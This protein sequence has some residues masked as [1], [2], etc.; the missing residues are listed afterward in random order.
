MERR[1]FRIYTTIYFKVCLMSETKL[2][3]RFMEK[4]IEK[5]GE[6]LSQPSGRNSLKDV[7]QKKWLKI[8]LLCLLGLVL[9]AGV[10]YAGLKMASKKELSKDSR[11]SPQVTSNSS[12]TPTESLSSQEA[13]KPVVNQKTPVTSPEKY[14]FT[15]TLELNGI[16][17]KAKFPQN[18]TV[19]LQEEGFYV[20]KASES[21]A[22]TFALKNYDGG[23]RRAWFQREYPWAKNYAMEPFTGAGHSG[24]IAYAVKPEDRPGAFFYFAVVNNKMLVVSGNNYI[25]NN[26]NPTLGNTSVFFTTDI[27]KFKSFL[28]TIELTSSQNVALETYPQIS[29]LYR[30]SNT[31]KTVWEDAT[32]GLKITTP[33]WTESRY[34]RERD[35]NGKFTYTDW[36]RTYPEAKTYD[37]SYFSEKIKRVEVT[38]AYASSQYLSV[39]S[40]KYQGKSFSEV[41]NELLIPA[42]F[43]TTEWKSS[44]AECTSSD[45]C[46]TKDEVVQN[47]IVKKQIKIGTLDA[48]L[49]NMNQDFSNKNDCRSEDTWMIKAQN[50]QF[51]LSNIL[52]DSET[53]KLESL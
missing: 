28:S 30:W 52:P 46:Y 2:E 20:I 25:S 6:V 23:G 51:V 5:E 12:V 8:G 15:K 45:F 17:V 32:L 14:G 53:I 7:L 10:F 4:N 1:K 33:D 31:R 34:T 29:D 13:E 40:L 36:A 43:C 39:L 22:V 48:Q 38:G 27:Q 26:V 9:L 47:L 41:A 16:G 21:D 44:K 19:S 42:G 3:E 24:Y 11:P 18:V 49:R 35:A 37:S 50:G